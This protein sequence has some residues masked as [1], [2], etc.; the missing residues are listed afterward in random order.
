MSQHRHSGEKVTLVWCHQALTEIPWVR[1]VLS[2]VPL[3]EVVSSD[4]E[5]VSDH[6]IYVVG[7]NRSLSQSLPPHF[8]ERLRSSRGKGLIHLSDERYGGGYDAYGEF[9]FVIRNYD[10]R[11]FHMP[12]MLTIPLGS[13]PAAGSVSS[14]GPASQRPFLWCFLGNVNGARASMARHFQALAP[15]YLYTYDTRKSGATRM[16]PVRYAD[17]LRNSAFCPCPMGNVN[18]ETYRVYEALEAGCIPLVE[19]R[20][21]MPYFAELMPGNPIP[22]FSSWAG[23]AQFVEAT[24]QERGALDRLQQTVSRW[25]GSYK[26]SLVDTVRDFCA[27]GLEGA[28][29]EELHR[30]WRRKAR[31][32]D[33]LWRIVELSR[34]HSFAAGVHRMRVIA[35]RLAAQR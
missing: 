7:V 11:K 8:I 1:F 10:A 33:Q 9:D 3:T 31:A 12:G 5:H 19:R 17:V 14:G 13:A 4:F 16:D 2:R 27:A 26:S 22:A 32:A 35:H 29:A 20:L 28:F 18:L 34:H 30:H 24:R 25:W 23:A 15:H 6:S 21:C